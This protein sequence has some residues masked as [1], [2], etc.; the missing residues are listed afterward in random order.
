MTKSTAPRTHRV[1]GGFNRSVGGLHD[2]RRHPGDAANAFENGHAVHSGHDEIEEDQ[3]D[4]RPFLAF[5]DLDGLLSR[6][7]RF[8]F[9]TKTLDCFFENSA[10]GRIVIDDENTL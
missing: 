8:G 3:A 6:T 5:K 9:K 4:Q 10:L 7:A 1:D 2:D